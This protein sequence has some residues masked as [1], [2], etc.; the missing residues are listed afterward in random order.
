VHELVSVA[1]GGCVVA[2]RARR[3]QVGSSLGEWLLGERANPC[4]LVPGPSVCI[5]L[6]LS[7]F[8]L[9]APWRFFPELGV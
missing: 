9:H 6:P 1:V 4:A 5:A 3:A 8:I 2:G 7:L